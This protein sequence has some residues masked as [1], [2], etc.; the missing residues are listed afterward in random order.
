MPKFDDP[1]FSYYE[2][3]RANLL[4]QLERMQSGEWKVFD[5]SIDITAQRIEVTTLRLAQLDALADKLAE[6]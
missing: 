3:E 6:G 2:Q 4:D 1:F 5:R